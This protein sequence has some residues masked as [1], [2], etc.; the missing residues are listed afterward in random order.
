[1]AN[2]RRRVVNEAWLKYDFCP[3]ASGAVVTATA[4]PESSLCPQRDGG[5]DDVK[6]QQNLQSRTRAS[7]P[8]SQHPTR[9]R[10]TRRTVPAEL[11]RGAGKI[12]T[13]MAWHVPIWAYPPD[14]RLTKSALLAGTTW[15]PP[16]NGIDA[17]MFCSAFLRAD[18]DERLGCFQNQPWTS[19][20][21]RLR[22][23][24]DIEQI[25]L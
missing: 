11:N 20:S 23:T 8:V 9:R 17:C 3:Q 12:R 7:S 1:M 19:R 16:T 24:P 4:A 15:P 5:K 21:H 22:L 13:K 6:R 25:L 18:G 14:E 10:L 2:R